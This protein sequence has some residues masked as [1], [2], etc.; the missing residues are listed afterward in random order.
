MSTIVLT[1]KSIDLAKAAAAKRLES[2]KRVAAKHAGQ[3][4][5]HAAKKK[6]AKKK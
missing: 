2:F 1:F 6:A 4:Q 3:T 5:S